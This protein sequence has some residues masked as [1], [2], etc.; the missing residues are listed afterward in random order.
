[1]SAK[2]RAVPINAHELSP[3]TT[4]SFYPEPFAS[5][6]RGR[7][8][9]QLGEFFGL[10]SFGVNL[11]SLAPMSVSSLR[12]SHLKQDEFIYIVQGTPTLTT[13]DGKFVLS[14]GMCIGFPAG[15]GN[16]HNLCNET[17]DVVLYLEI[18]D[19]TAGEE[20]S[21]PDDDLKIEQVEG[22]SVYLHKDGT[23][24]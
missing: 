24:Y 16:A 23:A 21:Y 11:T 15:T 10:K 12:H 2:P 19:R 17:P 9:R 7:Q 6:M 13:N 22:K 20:V 18:G 1:M 8:K 14:P 5:R 3:R 4:T